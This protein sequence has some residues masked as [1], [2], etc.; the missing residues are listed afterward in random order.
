MPCLPTHAS[1]PCQHSPKRR[2]LHVFFL[3]SVSTVAKV[4]SLFKMLKDELCETSKGN[5]CTMSQMH[6]PGRVRT[7]TPASAGLRGAVSCALGLARELV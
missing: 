5:V 1:A 4:L 6:P 3:N 2:K 7:G